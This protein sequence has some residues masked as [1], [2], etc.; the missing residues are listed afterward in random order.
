MQW[1]SSA[2]TVF[3]HAVRVFLR[4]VI[5]INLGPKVGWSASQP[6]SM[7]AGYHQFD[8]G[9]GNPGDVGM[10]AKIIEL[11]GAVRTLMR[12]TSSLLPTLL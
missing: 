9:Y 12:S 11:I 3:L 10:K 6:Q 7:N 4:N 8:Q 1:Q 2:K 5:S